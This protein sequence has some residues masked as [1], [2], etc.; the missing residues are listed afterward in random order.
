MRTGNNLLWVLLLSASVPAFAQNRY[1]RVSIRIPA[2]GL[3]W[4]ASRG[5]SFDHGELNEADN[6]FIT[7]LSVKQLAALKATGTSYSVLVEDEEAA[8][9]R[10]YKKGNFYRNSNALMVDGKLQF[11]QS[12]ASAIESVDVPAAF[13][14]GSYAGYYTFNEM[15]A[16]IKYMVDTYPDLVDTIILPIKSIEG[17][18]LIAVKISDN[19]GTDENEPEALYTGLHHAREGM[20]MMNL[21]FFMNYLLEHYNTDARIKDLV[22][23]RELYFIPCV[24]PDGYVYNETSSPGGG[25]MW[26]KNRRNNGGSRGVD[27]NRNYGEDWGEN[28][29]DVSISTNPNDEDYI[30]SA[31][32]SEPETRAIRAFGQSRHFTIAI[33]HHAYG[34]YY[35][36]PFGRPAQHPFT[37]QDTDFY[38]YASALMGKY[39]A[40][41]AGDGLATVG[42]YAVGNSRDWYMIGD[43][44]T[45]SKQKT[46]GYTVEIGPGNQGFWPDNSMII[47]IAKTMFFA[48][49]QMAYM[50]GSYFELQDLDAINFTATSGTHHFS[51]R[52]I[53]L[54]DA[55]VTISFQPL[56]N[57]TF[58]GSP[59]TISSMPQYFNVQNQSIAYQLP[60][61][62]AAGTRIRFLRRTVSAGITT[63]DTI[64]KYYQ[65][66]QLMSEDME[67]V[68]NWQF[69]GNW[70]SSTAAAFGG[71]RSISESPTGNYVSGESSYA[72]YGNA[73]DLSDAVSAH[74]VFRVRHRAQNGY[75][76]LQ[77]QLSDGSGFEPVC[78][79]STIKENVGTI[80]N[81]PAITGN[82]VI[83]NQEVIDLKDYLGKS[84][85]RLRFGFFANSSKTDDGFYIDNVELVKSTLEVLPLQFINVE[86]RKSANGIEV[87][88]KIAEDVNLSHFEVERS[89]DGKQF[90][91]IAVV[92]N[93]PYQITDKEPQA[94][95]YYRIRAVSK[96]KRSAYSRT[97]RLDYQ[98]SALVS[99]SPNPASASLVIRYETPK[100][101]SFLLRITDVAGRLLHQQMLHTAGGAGYRQ[102]NIGTWKPQL[103]IVMLKD[104]KSGKETITKIVKK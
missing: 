21:F 48:N 100:E 82:R 79:T 93:L 97:V 47:P 35:V 17:R 38:T 88:W 37:P 34:N 89:S 75:D 24:N 103:Y 56:E 45:G 49:I 68:S 54:T 95:N 63:T 27:L 102:L 1:S 55:P 36:T 50:A 76:K 20:S 23:S 41:S 51:V 69:T 58:T 57:I 7:T 81:E 33:D 9:V 78:A 16:K 26:R 72:T 84:N 62:I 85:V 77:V 104:L 70:G 22:D 44:G 53:G 92:N 29:P 3:S 65:P 73:I 14:E 31:P 46:Y 13:T 5:V 74:L 28:G 67:T 40:Y 96:D 2:Q 10:Q 90:S 94:V 87:S 59:V 25:G 98:L 32:W 66:V 91:T 43:I 99:V 52:R 19:A 101:T 71:S 39:N 42:Y 15:Q 11:Q 30:G 18:P 61:S 64:V 80:G 6:T 86:A 60:A 12:C 83:W 4:L 8:A